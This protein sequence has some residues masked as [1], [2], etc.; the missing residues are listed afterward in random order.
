VREQPRTASRLSICRAIN[1][2]NASS[3]RPDRQPSACILEGLPPACGAR[4]LSLA[5]LVSRSDGFLSQGS[6]CA[7]IFTDDPKL[8]PT[9]PCPRFPVPV[10]VP[11]AARGAPGWLVDWAA[12]WELGCDGW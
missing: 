2:R 5:L 10:P 7:G 11:V 12:C 1:A 4:E 8:R 9:P 3:P 6:T